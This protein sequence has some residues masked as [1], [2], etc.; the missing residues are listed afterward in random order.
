MKT[1]QFLLRI[2]FFVKMSTHNYD[3][4]ASQDFELFVA[5]RICCKDEQEPTHN[6]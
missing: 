6:Y 5:Q 2:G 3:E 4:D 1:R